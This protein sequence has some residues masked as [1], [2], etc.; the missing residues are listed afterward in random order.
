MGVVLAAGVLLSTA[1]AAVAAEDRV[2][3]LADGTQLRYG[4]HTP[5]SL[6]DELVPLIVGL[7]Y[8]WGG[9]PRPPAYYGR[10]YMNLLVL[11]A[12]A[13]VGAIIVAP[14]C[15]G[16]GWGDARSDAAILALI[17]SVQDEFPVDPERIVITGYSL[18]GMGTWT[19]VS[20]HPEIVSAA[21]PVAGRPAPEMIAN[22]DGTPVL[23]IHSEL[24]EV[25]PI[26]PTRDAIE[27]LRGRQFDAELEAVPNLTHYQTPRFATPLRRAVS[28]LEQVW[29]T[30]ADSWSE[31]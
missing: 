10:D 4:L 24:D 3:P 11:P 2:L 8:G 18:G 19:F 14:D 23:A 26:G 16:R 17:E 30:A 5:E 27:A 21:I 6:G 15:P 9:G 31:S 13:E 25:V 22:W 28:W 29:A 20:R 1:T 12:L 7:H